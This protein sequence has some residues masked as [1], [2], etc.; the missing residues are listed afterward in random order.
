MPYTY[1]LHPLAHQDMIDAYEW[2]E[3]KSTGLG[4]EFGKT[5]AT[6]IGIILS[7][8]FVF[9][10]KAKKHYREAILQKFPFII[11]YKINEATKSVYILSIHH[12]KKHPRNKFRK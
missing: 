12:A 5:I 6:K 2:Y 4:E 11:V 10:S 3:N 9:S 8:P 1:T 7:N